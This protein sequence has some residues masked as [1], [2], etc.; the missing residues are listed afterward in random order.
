MTGPEHYAES[1][2]IAD[3][4]AVRLARTGWVAEAEHRHINKPVVTR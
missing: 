2:V 1:V 4:V 3:V